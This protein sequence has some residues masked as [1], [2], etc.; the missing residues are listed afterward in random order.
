MTLKFDFVFY[1]YLTPYENLSLGGQKRKIS[2][3]WALNIGKIGLVLEN[4]ANQKLKFVK[5]QCST[6]FG[7]VFHIAMLTPSF[8]RGYYC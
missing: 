5:N 1:S 6:R 8:A 2:G 4:Y 7:I 3:H